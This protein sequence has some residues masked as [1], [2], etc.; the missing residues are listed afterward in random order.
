[1]LQVTVVSGLP[2]PGLVTVAANCCVKPMSTLPATGGAGFAAT[3][4]AT[5]L[6]TVTVEVPVDNTLATL[7]AVTVTTP[8]GV[9][10]K[11]CG[12]V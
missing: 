5:S 11:I 7:V 2:P 9:C 4:T 12:A 8:P 6:W 3:L 10:G 1:M